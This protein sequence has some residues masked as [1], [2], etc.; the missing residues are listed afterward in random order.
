M[1]ALPP[2]SPVFGVATIGT[3]LAN[4]DGRMGAWGVKKT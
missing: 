3:T 1:A 4:D 2:N